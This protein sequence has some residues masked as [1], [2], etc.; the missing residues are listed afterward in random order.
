M[1]RDDLPS[2]RYVQSNRPP[3]G[4]FAL[5]FSLLFI[6]T[7]VVLVVIKNVYSNSFLR[8]SAFITL[9][10]SCFVIFCVSSA[11]TCTGFNRIALMLLRHFD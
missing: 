2:F 8:M 9:R 3:D 4:L 11:P 1:Q 10:V 7:I 6:I 5:F